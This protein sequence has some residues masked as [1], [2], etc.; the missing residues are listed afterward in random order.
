MKLDIVPPGHAASITIPTRY[1]GGRFEIIAS[2]KARRGKIIIWRIKP[3]IIFLGFE[4]IFFNSPNFI[5]E[6][7]PNMIK[8]KVIERRIF[9]KVINKKRGKYLKI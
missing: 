6:P 9:I 1:S 5:E 8:N 7:T 2:K 4:N 3:K